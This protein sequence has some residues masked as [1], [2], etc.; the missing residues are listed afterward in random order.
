M[1]DFH[2]WTA[3]FPVQWA[4][5]LDDAVLKRLVMFLS[6]VHN[7]WHFVVRLF[8]KFESI[9]FINRLSLYSAQNW[10][11]SLIMLWKLV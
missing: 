5:S 3:K 6:L 10:V 4:I 7:D 1:F 11:I 2:G 9:S 8:Q